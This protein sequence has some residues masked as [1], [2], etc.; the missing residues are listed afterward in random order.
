M[1]KPPFEDHLAAYTFAEANGL[2]LAWEGSRA[3]KKW[4]AKLAP[5][6]FEIR[7]VLTRKGITNVGL[8]SQQ[9]AQDPD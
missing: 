1:T 3:F 7:A 5:S 6:E 9:H 4:Q 2:V 8:F